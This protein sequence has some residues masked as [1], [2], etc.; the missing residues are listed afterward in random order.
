MNKAELLSLANKGKVEINGIPLEIVVR[1]SSVDGEP[2]IEISVDPLSPL[3]QPL[4][5]GEKWVEHITDEECEALPLALEEYKRKADEFC[6][7]AKSVVKAKFNPDGSF[8]YTS[9]LPDFEKEILK[10]YPRLLK[11]SEKEQ[12]H[13]VFIGDEKAYWRAPGN[14]TLELDGVQYVPH[15]SY[16]LDCAYY[17]A[18]EQIK[19]IGG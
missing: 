1:P 10:D 14:F 17:I 16:W 7:Q 9:P 18:D 3:H 11:Q 8:N 6:E 12:H 13:I 4:L 15:W 19:K 5:L 2:W